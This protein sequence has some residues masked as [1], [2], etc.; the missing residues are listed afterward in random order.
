MIKKLT[1]NEIFSVSELVGSI[2]ENAFEKKKITCHIYA[3]KEVVENPSIIKDVSKIASLAGTKWWIK[4]YLK[5]VDFIFE[6]VLFLA[7]EL[8]MT[9][10]AIENDMKNPLLN[11]QKQQHAGELEV[12]IQN[13]IMEPCSMTPQNMVDIMSKVIL[14]NTRR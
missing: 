4:T 6:Q 11:I 13:K 8:A 3:P 10:N 7:V 14:K 2:I 1:E 5:E 12:R 9:R